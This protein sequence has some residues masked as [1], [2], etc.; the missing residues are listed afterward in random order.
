MNPLRT[1]YDTKVLELDIEGLSLKLA[2][3]EDIDMLFNDLVQKGDQHIDVKDERIPYWADLWPSAIALSIHLVKTKLIENSSSVLEIG[4]GLGLPGIVAGMLGANVT[5]TDYMP[6]P[7][8]FARYNW[9]LN[10]KAT[11]SFK[12]LDWRMP[13]DVTATEILLASDVAYE[14]RSF[15]V[16]INAFKQLS[17]QDGLIVMSEPNRKYAT[18]FFNSLNDHG[19]NFKTFCYP[20]ALNNII[21]NVNVYEITRFTGQ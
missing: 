1:I 19:F 11:A 21:T 6:E 15:D 7:L 18:A 8:E 4:C 5:L 9:D 10:N 2:S 13:K 16:L 14:K 3:V 12:I 17:K 20:V